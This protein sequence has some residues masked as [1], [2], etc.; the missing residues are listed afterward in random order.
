VSF[1]RHGE[2]HRGKR[3]KGGRRGRREGGREG[4]PYLDGEV[5]VAGR[6]DNV[7]VIIAPGAVGSG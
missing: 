4:G 3:G 6:V 5:D 1:D 7:D 2:Q